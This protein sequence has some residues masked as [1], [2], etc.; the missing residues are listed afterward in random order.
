MFDVFHHTCA[1][2]YNQDMYL[3]HGTDILKLFLSFNV[4]YIINCILQRL[5][6]PVFT[7][8]THRLKILNWN[9]QFTHDILQHG[10]VFYRCQMDF[11]SSGIFRQVF[12][13]DNFEWAS[14]RHND[15]IHDNLDNAIFVHHSKR[16]RDI[17]RSTYAHNK[18]FL[19]VIG[20]SLTK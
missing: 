14:W 18:L 13:G 19:L 10:H 20:T 2:T 15:V 9:V 11:L 8:C 6:Q 7:K 17:F 5:R 16:K 3:G 4:Q 12:Q 1:Q